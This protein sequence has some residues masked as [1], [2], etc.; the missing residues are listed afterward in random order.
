MDPAF[1]LKADPDPESQTNED[2]DTGQT[3]MSQKVE[4]L[5]FTLKICL[6]Q[7]IGQVKKIPM[8]VHV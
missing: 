2:Q 7:V 1:Y 5:F 3:L 8:K 6:Q 4:F